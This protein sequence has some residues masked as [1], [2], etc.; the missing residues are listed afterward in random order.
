M[1]LAQMAMI[2]IAMTEELCCVLCHLMSSVEILLSEC[3]SGNPGDLQLFKNNFQT[4]ND[5]AVDSSPSII[6]L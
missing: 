4:M 6:Y 5:T 2:M 3:W 1:M